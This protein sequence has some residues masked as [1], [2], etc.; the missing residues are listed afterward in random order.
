[1]TNRQ[2]IIN[3]FL[4][5]K[6]SIVTRQAI[7][8]LGDRGIYKPDTNGMREWEAYAS[9]VQ[10]EADSIRRELQAER[11]PTASQYTFNPQP[12]DK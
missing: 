9:L 11:K 2:R 5:D 3:H 10:A 6:R 12:I 1:M 8:N 4:G 7:L